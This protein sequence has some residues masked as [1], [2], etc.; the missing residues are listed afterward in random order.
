MWG[1]QLELGAVATSYIPT[2][3]AKATRA[4]DIN[5]PLVSTLPPAVVLPDPVPVM[6]VQ[7]P[8][9]GSGGLS[10]SLVSRLHNDDS[11]EETY[12]V[13]DPV[14]RRIEGR[15]RKAKPKYR[16]MKEADDDIFG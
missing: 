12:E 4:A 14:L 1:G 6:N 9:M 13:Q 3:T 5:Q 2:G 8:G 15:K 10:Q 16:S 7:N 11:A